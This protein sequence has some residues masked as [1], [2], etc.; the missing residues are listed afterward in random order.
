MKHRLF[1]ARR[2]PWTVESGCQIYRGPHW[3]NVIGPTGD[4]HTVYCTMMH[5]VMAP[6]SPYPEFVAKVCPR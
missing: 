5:T 6:G 1:D 3:Y 2:S 4:M